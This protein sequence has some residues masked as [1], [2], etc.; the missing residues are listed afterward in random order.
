MTNQRPR[1]CTTR[2]GGNPCPGTGCYVVASGFG[3]G[4]DWYLNL[5]AHPDA[6]AQIGRH[7]HHVHVTPLSAAEGGQAM[8][9]YRHGATPRPARSA[10]SWATKWT[11]AR[12]TTAL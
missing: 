10:A 9:R 8:A 7:R 4:A 12:T 3:T 11:A 5:L 6:T 1:R 2:H